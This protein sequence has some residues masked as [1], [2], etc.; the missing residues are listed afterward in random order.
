M[1]FCFFFTLTRLLIFPAKGCCY[2]NISHCS[3]GRHVAYLWIST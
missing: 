3:P 1:P 2:S